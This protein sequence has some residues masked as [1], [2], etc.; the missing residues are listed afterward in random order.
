VYLLLYHWIVKNRHLVTHLRSEFE[1]ASS[2]PDG[3]LATAE[4]ALHFQGLESIPAPFLMTTNAAGKLSC[5]LYDNAAF[6]NTAGAKNFDN[7]QH[8][9]HDNGGTCAACSY[10]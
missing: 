7:P 1:I 6:Y 3:L 4:L 5:S 9:T 8:I 2:I 10:A